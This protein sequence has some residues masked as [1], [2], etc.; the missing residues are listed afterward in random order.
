[1]QAVLTPVRVLSGT[2]NRGPITHFASWQLMNSLKAAGRFI[3]GQR[4]PLDDACSPLSSY[5]FGLS[6]I[7]I[8]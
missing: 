3:C 4:A 1:M 7:T 8:T 2:N 5:Q 6:A